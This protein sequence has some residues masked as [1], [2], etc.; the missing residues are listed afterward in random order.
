MA[1]ARSVPLDLAVC[2]DG[3]RTDDGSPR[4]GTC[5]LRGLTLTNGNRTWPKCH[6]E[7]LE[8]S[9]LRHDGTPYV[10]TAY[11]RITHGA[12]T[13]VAAWWLACRDYQDGP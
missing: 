12:G 8:V 7:A 6:A 2:R 1:L 10:G 5:A 3:D 4:C 13:D 9:H 11:P